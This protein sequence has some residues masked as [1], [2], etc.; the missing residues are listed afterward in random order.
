MLIGFKLKKKIIAKT[1]FIKRANGG[2]GFLFYEFETNS[3]RPD[4]SE[5][6]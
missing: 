1:Y 2:G 5:T 3:A 4:T 6:E